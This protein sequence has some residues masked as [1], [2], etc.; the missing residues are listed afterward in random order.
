[1]LATLSIKNFSLIEDLEVSFASGLC[2]LTG[3]T[4][5]GKS[6]LL[7]ALSLILGQ[8]ADLTT[9]RPGA[10]KC[11]VE[12]AFH[13][14]NH[15]LKTLFDT[16]DLDYE[17]ETIIRRELSVSG[18]SR[19]FV[20]DTPT[21]LEALKKLG[22]ALV[23][24][25]TQRQTL[26]LTDPAFY[27]KFIDA[28]SNDKS[29]LEEYKLNYNQ[30]KS[31]T[32]ALAELRA[33]QQQSKESLDYN[34][35]LLEE[36]DK[37]TLGPNCMEE[38]DEEATML[39]NAT[40]L[41]LALSEAVAIGMQDDV[42]VQDQLRTITQMMGK[43]APLGAAYET[44]HERLSSVGIEIA[45]ILHEAQ[46][47]GEAIIDD[48]LRLQE[49]EDTL[50]ILNNLCQKHQVKDAAGLIEKRE[51]LRQL[52][53]DVENV[54]E[55]IQALTVTLKKTEA[56]LSMA[57]SALRTQREKS[58][59][60]LTELMVSRTRDLGMEHI[61][62]SFRFHTLDTPGPSGTEEVALLFSANKGIDFAPIGKAASGGELSR[63]MLVIKSIMAERTQ[64]PTLILDEIDTGVSGEMAKAMGKRMY[65][66]SR[67]L[68]VISITHL[69]Q[70]AALADAHYKVYK[71]VVNNTTQTFL[72]P[73][74]EDARIEELA[75]ML[76]GKNIKESALRH[77]QELRNV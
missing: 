30:W 62:F 11:V 28:F 43:I 77:A 29:L 8:R 39:R 32:N 15:N 36:L 45:D 46:L 51:H 59:K 40:G 64:L 67:H 26:Q 76:G 48:P 17:S 69:P 37:Q 22:T 33:R 16:L 20:N 27:L 50:S 14:S 7:E 56:A 1:M 21:T 42:G 47:L 74:D 70:I 71:E 75:E 18:K 10:N 13:V 23:D 52:C 5:S 41:R 44:L 61:G 6:I 58:C 65:E 55:Q 25:H 49:V 35:F 19:A 34:R 4:G 12:A 66:L 2:M 72:I 60:P 24:I 31:T 38:L 54:D 3:E 9:I 53:G 57:A 68:Q 63:I 73:L